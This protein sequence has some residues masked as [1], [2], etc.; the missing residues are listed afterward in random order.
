M[1]FE[2]LKGKT[3]SELKYCV[4]W[5]ENGVLKQLCDSGSNIASRAE[6]LKNAPQACA[7]E[8]HKDGKVY[9]LCDTGPDLAKF[10]VKIK[11]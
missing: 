6:L 7:F 9:P 1:V 3:A 4:V 8:I 5:V 11:P 10:L 2:V